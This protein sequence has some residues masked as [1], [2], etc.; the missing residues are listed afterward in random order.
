MTDIKYGYCF[1]L[2]ESTTEAELIQRWIEERDFQDKT[3]ESKYKLNE[4]VRYKGKLWKIK[5]VCG[6]NAWGNEEYCL[7]ERISTTLIS[8]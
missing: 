2:G 4:L 3:L 1:D 5:E 7:E 8:N 6:S